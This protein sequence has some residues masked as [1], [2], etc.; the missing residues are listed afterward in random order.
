MSSHEERFAANRLEL[1][2]TDDLGVSVAD[3]REWRERQ[4]AST[5]RERRALSKI[6]DLLGRIMALEAHEHNLEALLR[7]WFD[8]AD[9]P[10]GGYGGTLRYRTEAEL[11]RLS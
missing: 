6:D 8:L 7:E 1:T 10:G 5:E 11:G 9:L 3:I 2:L 4:F